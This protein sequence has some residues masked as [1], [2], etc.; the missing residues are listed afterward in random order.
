MSHEMGQVRELATRPYLFRPLTILD[1]SP[2]QDYKMREKSSVS[3][4]LIESPGG[5]LLKQ[6]LFGVV[7]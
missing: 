4:G 1:E 3:T 2:F 6:S 5:N 7:C